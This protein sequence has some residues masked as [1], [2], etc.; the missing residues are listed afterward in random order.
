MLVVLVDLG[1]QGFGVDDGAV[2]DSLLFFIFF[3]EFDLVDMGRGLEAVCL[4]KGKGIN[5]GFE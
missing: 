2:N 4:G 3:E 5:F 1:V